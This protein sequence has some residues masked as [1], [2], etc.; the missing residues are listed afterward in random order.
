MF[1]T[2]AADVTRFA[3][4][5]LKIARERARWSMSNAVNILCAAPTPTLTLT[6]ALL[7][8]FVAIMEADTQPPVPSRSVDIRIQ[9][10]N[11]TQAAIA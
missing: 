6:V 4:K 5:R 8:G 9:G 2:T 7:F 3:G 10:A 1:A 11:G